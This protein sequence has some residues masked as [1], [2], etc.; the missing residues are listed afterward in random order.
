[1]KVKELLES[2]NGDDFFDLLKKKASKLD[3]DEEVTWESI[4]GEEMDTQEKIRACYLH[5]CLKYVQRDYL[6]NAS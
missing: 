2:T 1:M 3:S 5:A 4:F 6:T